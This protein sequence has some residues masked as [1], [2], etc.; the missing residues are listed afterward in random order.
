[1]EVSVERTSGNGK[2][3]ENLLITL[4]W[5]WPKDFRINLQAVTNISLYCKDHVRYKLLKL[6]DEESAKAVEVKLD[7]TF[8][9]LEKKN[10]SRNIVA[11]ILPKTCYR[12]CWDSKLMA[13]FEHHNFA[14]EVGKDCREISPVKAETTLRDYLSYDVNQ[15]DLVI[16]TNVT[17]NSGTEDAMVTVEAIQLPDGI[18]VHNNVTNIVQNFKF[19]NFKISKIIL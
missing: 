1:M 6:A 4:K 13:P 5:I 7:N 11:N 15:G 16:H 17:G 3:V 12:I 18:K 8:E 9:I 2:S 14:K 19:V 10:N